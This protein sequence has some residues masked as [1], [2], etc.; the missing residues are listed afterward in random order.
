MNQKILFKQ[1]KMKLPINFVLIIIVLQLQTY[2]QQAG[3]STVS[4]DDSAILSKIG[5]W[6]YFNQDIQQ[7][8]FPKSQL[9][10][11]TKRIETLFNLV[12]EAYPQNAGTEPHWSRSIWATSFHKGKLPDGSN[13][14]L[15][16]SFNS[17]Y[18]FYYCSQNFAS[19]DDAKEKSIKFM[20]SEPNTALKICINDFGGLFRDYE[21]DF[22]INGKD[23]FIMAEWV[24][25]WKEYDVFS[26]GNLKYNKIVVLSRKGMLPYRY[27]T[28]KEYL[29]A[30]IEQQ[31]EMKES[32]LNN[33][34]TSLPPLRTPAEEE[35]KKN[36]GLEQIEKEYKNNPTVKA[37]VIKYYLAN[38]KTDQQER[39]EE[40]RNLTETFD[41][42]IK[43]Y[44]DEYKVSEADSLLLSPAIV[45]ISQEA[46]DGKK[47]SLVFSTEK[48]HGVTLVMENPDYFRQ[49][50]PYYIPQYIVMSWEWWGL[51]PE[52]TVKR[53]AA[54]EYFAE[55]INNFFP[56]EKLQAMIDK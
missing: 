3:T 7:E 4:C 37:R 52:T 26:H 28:R 20:A 31:S 18:P 33:Y 27:V 55:R 22:K 23:V 11:F 47:G 17:Y 14:G 38:Y 9:P 36:K 19:N 24:E 5:T 56:V 39:D 48:A 1:T 35:E 46:L 34:L 30:R 49:D 2:G 6:H 10:E 29:D 8:R 16:Y 51:N 32:W 41:S 13:Y 54:P 25:K 12:K 21:G 43:K 42:E 50:L 53:L 15:F 44:K 45:G 40:V